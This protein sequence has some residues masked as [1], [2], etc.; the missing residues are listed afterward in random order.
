MYSP[1]NSYKT[2]KGRGH[3]LTLGE[4]AV[5]VLNQRECGTNTRPRLVRHDLV[6]SLSSRLNEVYL[7]L[8]VLKC[9]VIVACV[10][11]FMFE[12][13]FLNVR[14]YWLLEVHKYVST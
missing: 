10:V 1:Q 7:N 13:N 4:Y 14:K 9:C 6:H 5:I 3:E 2:S 11:A 12:N 8:K